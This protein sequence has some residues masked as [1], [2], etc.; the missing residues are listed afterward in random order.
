M[1]H[2]FLRWR[3]AVSAAT[4]VMVVA[5]GLSSTWAFSQDDRGEKAATFVEVAIVNARGE[6]IG[7]AHL[8]QVSSGVRIQIAASRLDPGSHGF[9]IHEKHF[10]GFDFMTAGA[11]F[12][13]T[14]KEH[15]FHNPKGFHLGDMPNVM[16]TAE[17]RTTMEFY[18]EGVNLQKGDA[19]SLLGKSIL[20][21]DKADDYTTDPSGNS[22]DRIA[23]GNIPD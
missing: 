8:S 19:H 2:H 20:I 16:V 18:I 11:H 1:K 9:H 21:H 17:G 13:P 15:G 10:T 22:G 3:Y 5:F 4:L 7:A 23:G 14:H 6:T 12:N